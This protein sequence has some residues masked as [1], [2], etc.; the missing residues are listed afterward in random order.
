[1]ERSGGRVVFSVT[2]TATGLTA[3][4]VARMCEPFWRKD[5][6]RS[7]SVCAHAGLGLALVEAYTRLLDIDLKLRL[8]SGNLF[9]ATIALPAAA[10]PTLPIQP[11]K[12]PTHRD[13]PL[14]AQR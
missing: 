1:M 6:A 9:I 12:A 14:A 7:S 4:D 11:A 5:D 13:A 8:E 2:N 3:D 10:P